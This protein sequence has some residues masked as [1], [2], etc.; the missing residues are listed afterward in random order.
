M[1]PERKLILLPMDGSDQSMEVVK[2]V[3]RAVNL[4]GAEVVFLS[5]IDKMPDIFWD[6]ERDPTVSE[7]L[8]HMKDWDTYREQKMHE[9]FMAACEILEAAGLP[10]SAVTCNVQRRQS[11]I[12]RDIIEESKFGYDA[13]A[14]GRSGLGRMDESMLGSVAA[15]V[16]INVVDTP[17]CLLGGKPETGRILVGLD[18]SLGSIR[19]VNF[20]CRMLNASNP[21]VCLAH[22]VR[23]PQTKNGKP[24]DEDSVDK[25]TR[26]RE[27]MMKPVFDSAVKSLTSAGFA[28]ENISTRLIEVSG[29][30]AVNLFNEAKTGKFGTIVVGRRGVSDVAEFTM[31]RVPYKLGY[32]AR[33]VALWLVS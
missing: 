19:V 18:N 9:C 22:I 23:I 21:T 6:T 32:I 3:S 26:E 14:I 1:N 7:H 24:L 29:S 16:F 17:V 28:P 31:G 5:I 15:K 33:D 10:K 30:R 11:G 8:E 27:A 20:V 25:I 13:L 12:A 4:T 2:Y